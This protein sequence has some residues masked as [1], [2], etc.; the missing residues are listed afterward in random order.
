MEP[1]APALRKLAGQANST[2][3]T[4]HTRRDIVP[5][6]AVDRCWLAPARPRAR[7]ER[8][9]AWSRQPLQRSSGGFHER[10]RKDADGARVPD[11]RCASLR[12]RPREVHTQRRAPDLLTPPCAGVEEIEFVTPVDI[13]R[14]AGF[15]VTV[16]AL[17]CGVP[18]ALGPVR[19]A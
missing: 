6:G 9:S 17:R 11:G 10:V 4:V 8:A 1:T 18:P 15:E 5:R 19:F 3:H 16:A 14:R 12:R 2:L 13:W 7:R